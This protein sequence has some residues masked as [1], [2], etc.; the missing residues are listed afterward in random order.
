MKYLFI[1][2]LT[3]MGCSVEDRVVKFHK[4]EIVRYRIEEFYLKVCSGIGW[5]DDYDNYN[6]KYFVMN[7]DRDCPDAYFEEKDL[8]S[9]QHYK[10][11]Q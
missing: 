2:L 4:N 1:G 8:V 9:T 6:N 3:L 7:T 5:V 11:K 10:D